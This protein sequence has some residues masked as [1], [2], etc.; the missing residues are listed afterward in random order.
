MLLFCITSGSA[1]HARTG[2]RFFFFFFF[3]LGGGGGGGGQFSREL[4]RLYEY[5]YRPEEYDTVT[6]PQGLN[7]RGM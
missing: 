5:S 1:E 4:A 2:Q 3:F 6:S 7:V